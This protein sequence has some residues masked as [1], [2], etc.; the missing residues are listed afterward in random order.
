MPKREYSHLSHAELVALLRRRDATTHFGLVWERDAIERDQKLNDEFVAL[1]LDS[2]LVH[3]DPPFR[4]L[5]IEGDNFDALRHLL[6]TH[7]GLINVIYIDP[8]YNTGKSEGEGWVY[9]DRR[10]DPNSRFRH[11]TWLEFMFPRLQLAHDL[12]A[13]TGVMLV[14]IDDTE[15]YN[16]KLLMD[17]LF[18]PANFVANIVWKN[19]NE[20][21]PTRVAVEHEYILVY[22]KNRAE[23]PREWKSADHPAKEALIRIGDELTARYEDQNELQA[24]Y[25]AWFKENRRYLGPLD[26][27]KYI[28]K[29]GVYTGSQSVHKPGK[30]GYWYDVPHNVTGKPCKI[31][32]M[33]YR[34]PES[35]MNEL[36][37]S[38]KILFG[39]DETKI[40]E[41]KLYAR[42]FQSKLS[43]LI[44]LDGRKGSNELSRIFEGR[45]PF[46]NPKP[47][48]L[49]RE[50]LTFVSRPDDIVLD[51]F[52]GSGTT[53]HAVLQLNAQDGGQRRFVL[54]S[55]TEAVLD[56]SDEERNR[57][58]CRDVCAA[59]MRKVMSKG[60]GDLAPMEEGFAYLKADPILRHRL[61][62]EL[63]DQTIWNAI[64]LLHDL[65]IA[66]LR[67]GFG[68]AEDLA[69]G[70]IIY[71]PR[72][73]G[74]DVT[75][76]AERAEQFPGPICCYAWAPG[77]FENA[78]PRAS[79]F[80][81]PEVFE[82]KFRRSAALLLDDT[83]VSPDLSEVVE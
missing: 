10:F 57:N 31:P 82:K 53:G 55:S 50:L 74:R 29:D 52:A 40:I 48:E 79:I 83:K 21:N 6:M 49:I 2:N 34:F 17:R 63:D 9:N 4:H 78:V 23:N 42:E 41:L 13:E 7:A 51:F 16:L 32:L 27:Y 38:N 54:I 18:G 22:T 80:Q 19:A 56:G 24:A 45:L 3:G 15:L 76:F 61:E 71:A 70:A 39:E 69:G 43:S 77:R 26:R 73:K 64:L 30:G 65:P 47:T 33:G 25:T 14:S 67:E 62:L 36:L 46:N 5:I 75:E 44:E 68:W 8:P 66:S 60:D 20:N 28:D 1:R 72:S 37:A 81:L 58:I 12:L 11:S 59:R 35:S